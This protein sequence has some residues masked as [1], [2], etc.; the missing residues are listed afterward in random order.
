MLWVAG[1]GS[2]PVALWSAWAWSRQRT[3]RHV[4]PVVVGM[5]LLLWQLQYLDAPG[6]A[7]SSSTGGPA[8][9]AL[10]VFGFL[11]VAFGIAVSGAISRDGAVTR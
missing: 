9:V 7:A 1:C 10:P 5:L 3:R 4:G 11:A 6:L 8:C 2:L